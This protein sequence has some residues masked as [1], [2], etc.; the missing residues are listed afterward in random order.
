MMTSSKV[1]KTALPV[2]TY[3]VQDKFQEKFLVFLCWNK[4]QN[5]ESVS[6]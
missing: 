3:G 6:R 1:L 2:A 5:Q 4:T